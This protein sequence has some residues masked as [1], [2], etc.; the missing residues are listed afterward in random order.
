VPGHAHEVQIEP[1][2]VAGPAPATLVSSSKDKYINK[3]F[4]IRRKNSGCIEIKDT[5]PNKIT[6]ELKVP[7]GELDS[8]F[9]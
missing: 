6:I 1:G 7:S 9:N 2:L 8:L 3:V 5:E 4:S